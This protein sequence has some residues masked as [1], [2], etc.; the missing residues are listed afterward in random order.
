MNFLAN[1]N[2]LTV[3]PEATV[4][5]LGQVFGLE[6]VPIE[7]RTP[8]RPLGLLSRPA[9]V[10]A[11]AGR[12]FLDFVHAGFKDGNQPERS[13]AAMRAENP[14]CRGTALIFL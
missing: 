5:S 11:Y 12:A 3:L 2:C 8:H 4:L 14:Q 1:S 6:I 13:R 7:T 10:L 9:P